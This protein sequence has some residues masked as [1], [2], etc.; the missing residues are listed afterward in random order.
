MFARLGSPEFSADAVLCAEAGANANHATPDAGAARLE[1][2]DRQTRDIGLR[3]LQ[4]I[5]K[6]SRF[7]IF[8]CENAIRNDHSEYASRCQEL[9]SV[10]HVRSV[11]APFKR[12]VQNDGIKP[13]LKDHWIKVEEIA[14]DEMKLSRL[15]I[16]RP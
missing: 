9:V 2:I 6:R 8:A 16:F 4:K 14:P 1:R 10:Q 15:L 12:R 11:I 5:A 13:R 7:L 3:T